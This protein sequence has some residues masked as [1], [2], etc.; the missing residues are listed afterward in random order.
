MAKKSTLLTV[1]SIAHKP[2]SFTCSQSDSLYTLH[3]ETRPMLTAWL[4]PLPRGQL[5]CHLLFHNITKHVVVT[6]FIHTPYPP[7]PPTHTP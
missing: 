5:F 1:G 4:K 3:R 6:A 7:Y 2:P